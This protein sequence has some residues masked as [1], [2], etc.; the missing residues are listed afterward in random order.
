MEKGA[1]DCTYI[2]L[3]YRMEEMKDSNDELPTDFDNEIHKWSLEC[4]YFL[5]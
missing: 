5:S 4:K 3:N 1:H 2:F